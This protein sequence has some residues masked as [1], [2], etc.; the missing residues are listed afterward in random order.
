LLRLD[1][2]SWANEEIKAI[3]ECLAKD[4]TTMSDQVEAFEQNFSEYVGSKYSIMVNSGSS[5][6]LLSAYALTLKFPIKENK[7]KVIVPSLSWSTTYFPWI[8]LGY[9]LKFVDINLKNLNI[10]IDAVKVAFDDNVAGICVPHILGAGAD[11]KALL[12]FAQEKNLWIMEDTCES[13]GNKPSYSE[14]KMLGTFS[15][16]GTFSFFRSHHISTMEGGMIVT[17]DEELA[18]YVKSLRTHGWGRNLLPNEYLG[19]GSKNSWKSKFEFFLPGFNLRPLEISGAV[20]LIQLQKL[21]GFLQNRRQNAKI[22]QELLNDFDFLTLQEQELTGSW[23]AFAIRC[24]G[25]IR[26]QVV[27]ALESN[28]VE[29]RPVITGNFVNQ[30]V[31]SRIQGNFEV[32]G[33]LINSQYIEDNGFMIANHGRNLEMELNKISRIFKNL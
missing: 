19:I 26:D 3:N 21:D 12:S 2:S 28:G 9:K 32:S 15:N 4:Q 27:N 10:D 16:I 25:Q 5:A 13:L 1:E 22:F 20:G 31:M 23:M 18:V 11:I 14:N 24:K 6:N 8:Q 30:P 33:E 17:D 29:T 7:N